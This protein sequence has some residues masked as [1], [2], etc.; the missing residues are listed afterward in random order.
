[1]VSRPGSALG[2]RLDSNRGLTRPCPSE[3]F[4]EAHD[5]GLGRKNSGSLKKTVR[6]AESRLWCVGQARECSL[7]RLWCVGQARECSLRRQG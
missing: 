3:A 7:R 4:S 6:V 5:F 2:Q 1:M